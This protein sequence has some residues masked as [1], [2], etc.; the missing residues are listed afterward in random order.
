[1]DACTLLRHFWGRLFLQS[2]QLAVSDMKDCSTC[3]EQLSW[4]TSVPSLFPACSQLVHSL[5]TAVNKGHVGCHF[6]E[7]SEGE[8][9]NNNSVQ[10]SNVSMLHRSACTIIFACLRRSSAQ[11]VGPLQHL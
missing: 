5:F 11:F 2:Q 10:D 9:S 8:R 4:G 3:C 7:D 6:A 1:M